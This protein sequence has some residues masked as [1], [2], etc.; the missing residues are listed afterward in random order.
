MPPRWG[1]G[2]GKVRVGY[3]YA[4]PTGLGEQPVEATEIRCTLI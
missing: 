2:T 1:L 4:G 3:R